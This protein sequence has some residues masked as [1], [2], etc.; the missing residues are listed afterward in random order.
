VC[1]TGSGYQRLHEPVVVARTNVLAQPLVAQSQRFPVVVAQIF[2]CFCA[3]VLLPPQ[4]VALTLGPA[5]APRLDGLVNPSSNV[6]EATYDD[7]C[8]HVAD[9]TPCV[10]SSQITKRNRSHTRLKTNS[11]CGLFLFTQCVKLETWQPHAR[12]TVDPLAE[13]LPDEPKPR[14][15]DRHYILKYKSLPYVVSGTVYYRW[16]IL[17]EYAQATTLVTTPGTTTVVLS[18]PRPPRTPRLCTS[19]AS[20]LPWI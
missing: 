4:V 5:F 19:S 17:S 14:T 16:T 6:G 20:G 12:S 9:S 3:F 10:K 15:A 7:E 11:V 8:L 18:L 2:I 1:V 13:E